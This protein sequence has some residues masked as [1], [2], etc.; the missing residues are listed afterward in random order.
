M[1]GLNLSQNATGCMEI[2]NTD[3]NRKLEE[4]TFETHTQIN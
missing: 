2:L 3:L 4:I 1:S